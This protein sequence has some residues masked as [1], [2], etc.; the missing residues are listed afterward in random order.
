MRTLVTTWLGRHL[1][2]QYCTFVGSRSMLQH[3]LDRAQKVVSPDHVITVIGQ[4]H[5]IF[6]DGLHQKSSI[7]GQVVE[8]PAN[9][10]TVPGIFLPL[11]YIRAADPSATVIV[12]PSDHF[13][14]PEDAFVNHVERAAEM[15]ERFNDRLVMLAAVANSA[16]AQYGWIEPGSTLERTTDP[17]AFPVVRFYE[18][19]SPMEAEFFYR[20]GYFWNTMVMAAKVETLWNLGKRYFPEMMRKFDALWHVLYTV[21]NGMA[22][23]THERMALA[24]IYQDMERANFSRSI[25]EQVPERIVVLKMADV[26]WSDWG[27]PD[28]IV[29][30]LQLL[31]R[32]PSFPVTLGA[33]ALV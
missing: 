30:S 21:R 14:F 4:G 32:Y 18:K 10:D 33:N 12:F 2:K 17:Y 1:P 23:Q 15:A 24:H 20:K 27:S 28:R 16:E 31:G 22:N 19:P 9:R 26:Y 13:I 8:Q 5:G 25:L 7:P 11:T 3:T 29:E 6:L